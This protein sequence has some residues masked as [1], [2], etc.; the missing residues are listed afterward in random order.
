[1][2]RIGPLYDPVD[3]VHPCEMVLACV[4][5]GEQCRYLTDRRARAKRR[6]F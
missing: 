3:R 2:N 1:M 4:E 6:F 5:S